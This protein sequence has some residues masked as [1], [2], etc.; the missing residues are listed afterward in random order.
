MS[1]MALQLD[2]QPWIRI[3]AGG[4]GVYSF[5]PKPTTV[6]GVLRPGGVT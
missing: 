4:G 2:F 6:T 1:F 5:G 3:T